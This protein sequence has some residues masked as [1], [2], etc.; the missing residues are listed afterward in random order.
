MT[1]RPAP[2]RVA[3]ACLVVA[4]AIILMGIISAEAVYP[5]TYTTH[6]NEISDLGATKPPNSII[7]QPS[8]RIFN[9]VM[10]VSGVVLLAAAA[11]LHRAVDRKRLPIT[12]ALAG[13]GVLGVGIFPGNRVPMHPLFALLAFVAGGLSAVF[14]ARVQRAPASY[15]S[16]VL[17]VVALVN[18]ALGLA[19]D[20]TPFW[21]ELGAG[22][23]ERWV[24]YPVVLWFAQFGGYL[25]ATDGKAT[26]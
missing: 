25:L 1:L 20:G 10:M 7:R 2:A 8:A 4:A 9:A 3:G 13:L 17:G 12:L 11:A 5:A 19:G 24:A 22:G 15:L 16:G 18:L 14:S 26:A 21:G 23:I 6:E